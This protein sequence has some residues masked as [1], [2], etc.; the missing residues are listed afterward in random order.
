M[1]FARAKPRIMSAMIRNCDPMAR[2]VSA[3]ADSPRKVAAMTQN[4]DCPREAS[5]GRRTS[6]KIGSIS[7]TS[8]TEA[9]A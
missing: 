4:C 3:T 1:P 8:A 6:L 9:A 5:S 2:R 7:A